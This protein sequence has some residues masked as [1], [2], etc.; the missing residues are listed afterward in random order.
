MAL[1]GAG[2]VLAAGLLGGRY[3]LKQIQEVQ[4]AQ[5]LAPRVVF[6]LGGPGSG[7]GTNCERLVKEFGY[8]HLSAGDLLRAERSSGSSLGEEIENLM[9]QGL[10]VSSDITVRLIKEAMEKSPKQY[11]LIDGFPR[12]P[13]NLEVWNRDMTDCIVNFVLT[14]ECSDQIMQE[15][16][17]LRGETSGR[18][19]DNI[20]AIQKRLKV[21]H[22]VT[23]P[24]IETFKDTWQVNI[25]NSEA[26]KDE[27]YEKLRLLFKPQGMKYSL[28]DGKQKR[29]ENE[30]YE[31]N[32]EDGDNDI[33]SDPTIFS[34]YE[35]PDG[36]RGTYDEVVAHEAELERKTIAHDAE[37]EKVSP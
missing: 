1:Y 34:L 33:E 17:L 35:A 28:H 12:N 7:K 26:S 29:K 8:E 22:E 31:V 32:T 36:F 20:E 23:E 4:E 27:V 30:G 15:R 11:F 6:I 21:F 5:E 13:E 37:L 14:L 18:S 24:L 3:V 19:D 2:L 25:I 16:L 10:L 9:R